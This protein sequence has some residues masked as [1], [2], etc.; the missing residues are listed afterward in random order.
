MNLQRHTLRALLLMLTS[1]LISPC[2]LAESPQNLLIIQTDEHNFRTLGCYRETLSDDQAYIWGKDAIVE[3]PAIDSI[4]HSGAICTSFYATSPV[5][6]PSRASFFSGLYPH[7][8]GSPG[9][10]LPLNDDVVT[11]AKVLQSAGYSTGYAGKWHLDGSGKPQWMPKRRFGFADNRFMF[12]RGHWKKLELTSQ[13]PRV[14]ATRGGKPDYGIAGADATTYTTDWLTDRALEFITENAHKPFCYHLSLPDPHGPNTVRAPY[15]SMY[16]NTRI[17]PPLTFS[18]TTKNPNWA[19]AKGRNG[20]GQFRAEL[21]AKY[22]GMV[23]CI[24]DNVARLLDRLDELGLSETT[25][26]VITADH[27]DLCYEH[28]RLNKGIPYEASAK[29]PMI[30]KMPGRI[31]AGTVVQQALG[32]VDFAPTIL[33]LLGHPIPE[34]TQGRNAADL[35]SAQPTSWK[36][37]TFLRNA[38]TQAQWLAAVTDQYKLVVSTQD[39]PWLFDLQSDP[40]ELRNAVDVPANAAILRQLAGELKRYGEQFS[41]P[42]FQNDSLRNT[43]E[44]FATRTLK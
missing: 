32:T 10:D 40:D 4:A 17:R 3:T 39:S 15:D 18:R 43:I 5:C 24:D 35:L 13:G 29:I 36:D 30:V 1:T 22:F 9:N 27:G 42:F 26:I 23:R 38:G 7:N 37:I 6:T 19:P 21:M 2:L 20:A 34:A 11:F 41:D 44:R 12:N 14:G 31:P 33:S 25:A 28:G 16:R 8:T